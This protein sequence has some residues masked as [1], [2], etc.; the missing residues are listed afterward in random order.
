MKKT[1]KLTEIA[2]AIALAVVCSFIKVWEMP[3]G[4]S[5]ALTMIPILLIAFRCGTAA[6]IITGAVYGLLSMAI[7]GVVY[8]PM[9]ILL[10]YVLAF[11]LLGLAGLFP[12]KI[13][14]IIAGTCVGVGGRFISSL[15]SGAV[16]FASYAPEGQN[17]WV[18]S[19]V[20]QA[21][22]MIPELI[23]SVLVLLLLFLKARKIFEC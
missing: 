4:G 9:S 15:L 10:D 20:Y 13:G 5:I 19:L 17:P 16:L 21:T 2:V 3:Q 1:R 12:K 8:H 23:I 6:G 11:G 14:G 18:Y 22:Y 7:A